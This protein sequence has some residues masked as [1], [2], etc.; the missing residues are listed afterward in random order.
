VRAHIARSPFARAII[1]AT[2]TTLEARDIASPA[3][4]RAVTIRPLRPADLDG[5]L[6]ANDAVGWRDRRVLFEFYGARA[7]S[8]LFVA[9]VGGEIAGTGGATIF[10][11]ASPTGWVHG[12]V[13]RPEYQRTGLG[14]RLT[15][16]SI[17]WL[18]TRSAGAVLLL[19]TD[20]GRPVYE[21][22]GFTAGERY[23]SFTWPT[24]GPDPAAT[25]EPMHAGHL[26]AVL[27]LDREASGQDRSGFVTSLATSGWVATCGGE[28][29][30]FHLACPWG[31]GPTIA[32]DAAS[33]LAL[34][35]WAASMAKRPSRGPGLPEGNA[36][37]VQ[38]LAGLGITASRYVTRMW[39]GTPPAWRAEMIFGVFN[40]GVA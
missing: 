13:V 20:A 39:L 34:L 6:A 27:A 3:P 38:Y 2:E 16:T 10:P 33:G 14:A 25:V 12:I 7:D 31:G 26:S 40:F 37:A 17:E 11:G 24:T 15:E 18:R 5:A 23:G 32:R 28:V 29:A 30:G 1:L 22:L 21:R 35:R 4:A 36:A 19:A 9:E 8:A